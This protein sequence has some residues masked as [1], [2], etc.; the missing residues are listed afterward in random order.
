M[1][2]TMCLSVLRQD[3]IHGTPQAYNNAKDFFQTGVTWSNSVNVAQS[4][5][6]GNYSFSLGN[7]TSDGIVVLR[8]WIVIT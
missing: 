2:N 8:E 7:T 1:D 4:F 5:D 3:W 6:K